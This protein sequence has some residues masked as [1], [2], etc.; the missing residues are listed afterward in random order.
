VRNTTSVQI[1]NAN[2]RFNQVLSPDVVLDI[3][4][5]IMRQ[6]YTALATQPTW[7]IAEQ[8][9][10]HA[11]AWRKFEQ[12]FAAAFPGFVPTWL[13]TGTWAPSNRETAFSTGFVNTED[14]V[15]KGWEVELTAN[16]TRQLRLMINA[17]KTNAERTNV[18]GASTR[19]IYEFIQKA[20][21]NSD[22]TLTAAGLMRGADWQNETQADVWYRQNWIDYGVNQQLNGQPAPELVE[23]RANFVAN[24]NF[25]EGRLRGFGIGGAVRYEG[26]STIGFPYY[27]DQNGTVTVDINHP[28]RRDPTDRYDVWFRYR[29]MLFKDKVEWSVR[30]NIQNV[31]GEDDLIPVRSNPDGTAANYRILQ[32]QSWRLTNTFSF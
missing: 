25:T 3:E 27:F 24:Y 22:G 26:S 17:S 13:T 6:N 11:P 10:V 9:N 15:S 30:L 5:G 20:M 2:F 19:A 16:P 31:F 12:D 29:R 32:G 1:P 21:I 28:F 4:D 18:P 23:W 7:S 8:E 14:S